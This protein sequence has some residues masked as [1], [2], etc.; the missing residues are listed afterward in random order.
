M[1]KKTVVLGVTGGIAC[2]KSAALASKL[3]QRGYDVEVVLTKNATEFIGP[4][5][6]ESLTHNRA[7]VDTFDRNFQSHVEHV[8]LADK[9][10]LLIVAPATANII[11]KAAH[12]IADDMLSTTIL[13]C[14]CKKLMAPAMNT[15]MYDN[16]VTRDNL[17]TLRRY[18]WEVIEP[19]SGR[20]ACGAVGR[21]KMPEPE[22]LLE[23]V[24]HAIA[25][26]KDLSGVRVLVTAGP[27]Q[28]SLDPVRYLTNHSS[29]KMGYAIAR[30]AAWRGA[31]V[32]LVSGP[33]ALK[34]PAY[35]DTVDVV[36]VR[37]MFGAVTS[38]A[39]EQDVII[40]AAAVADYRP[41]Q[42]ADGK[43]KKGAGEGLTLELRRTDDILA[44]L[45]EHKR[46][47]QILCGFSMETEN[48]VEN[49][50]KKLIRKNLDIVAANS[51]KEEGAG[52]GVSTN[53]LTLITREDETQL[54]LLTKEEAAHRLLDRIAE[55]RGERA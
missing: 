39:G 28:E 41:A 6:F 54:P 32:T 48:L 12:G 24:D 51:L 35:V 9:A 14:D 52:F 53:V 46:P 27:T 16:P 33:T 30:A 10:D 49:S 47:G 11:A 37:E 29:G 19:A 31:E 38:R 20:L 5:T 40:K 7:M 44:Y 36:T 8:A 25:Y 4:H 55:L 13:A 2:Y 43:I 34:K 18:G 15:R 23:A 22:D 42:V 3:T 50:R 21:G 45:G 17:E 1:K 26:D